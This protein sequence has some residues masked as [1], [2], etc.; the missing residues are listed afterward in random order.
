VKTVVEK[1]RGEIKVD[2]LP[3]EGTTFTLRFPISDPML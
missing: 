2:S 1:H 3:D